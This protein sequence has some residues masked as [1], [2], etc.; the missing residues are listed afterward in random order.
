MKVRDLIELL[1]TVDPD[2]TV[3]IDDDDWDK[4][5]PLGKVVYQSMASIVFD[6]DH[7]DQ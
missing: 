5:Y 2:V 3:K 1:K 4:Y 7:G 6:L